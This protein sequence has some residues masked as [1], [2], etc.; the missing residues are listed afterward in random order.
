MDDEERN[1]LPKSD[2]TVMAKLREA[3]FKTKGKCNN[4]DALRIARNKNSTVEDVIRLGSYTRVE[5]RA[6]CRPLQGSPR[7]R[8]NNHAQ[9]IEAGRKVMLKDTIIW[10][11]LASKGLTKLATEKC[12]DKATTKDVMRPANA[13]SYMSQQCRNLQGIMNFA[14]IADNEVVMNNKSISEA[15][16]KVNHDPIR[17][18]HT[19]NPAFVDY[20]EGRESFFKAEMDWLGHAPQ[21]ILDRLN[22]TVSYA[23]MTQCMWNMSG[24]IR[25]TSMTGY[26][27]REYARQMTDFMKYMGIGVAGIGGYSYGMV[28]NRKNTQAL[29]KFMMT[30]KNKFDQMIKKG[31][32]VSLVR[33]EIVEMLNNW[34]ST[35]CI[36]NWTFYIR[37]DAP[38]DYPDLEKQKKVNRLHRSGSASPTV[39]TVSDE[40]ATIV[41]TADGKEIKFNRKVAR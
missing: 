28:R 19:H 22:P 26:K 14:K 5:P 39:I 41:K 3:V 27:A 38:T 31:F 6:Y 33:E 37:T 4:D 29:A 17:D 25:E 40:E 24:S 34:V 15:M 2:E 21:D 12:L 16:L 7:S 9:R 35:K 23:S 10:K 11:Y 13:Y 1:L 32:E 30:V 18:D 20:H 36:I 8:F